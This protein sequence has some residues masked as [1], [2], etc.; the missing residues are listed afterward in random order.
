MLILDHVVQLT[1][2]ILRSLTIYST[3]KTLLAGQNSDNRYVTEAF[4]DGLTARV[5]L[6]AGNWAPA[7]AAAQD[8][9]DN[10]PNPLENAGT[11]VANYVRRRNR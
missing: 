9:I 8:A 4:V 2:F 6:Y 5:N 10:F 1:M 3:A 11:G 7:A